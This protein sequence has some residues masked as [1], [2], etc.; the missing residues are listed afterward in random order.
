MSTSVVSAAAYSRKETEDPGFGSGSMEVTV[1]TLPDQ[2]PVSQSAIPG[3]KACRKWKREA[4]ELGGFFISTV[5][6]GK[7]LE[8]CRQFSIE[9]V[10]KRQGMRCTAGMRNPQ[11]GITKTAP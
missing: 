5:D 7:N 3:N 2:W 11:A 8:K 9:L 4:M 1:G 10:F 6:P